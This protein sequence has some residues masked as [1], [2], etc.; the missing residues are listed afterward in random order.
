MFN[1][2][3][4]IKNLINGRSEDQIN[5]ELKEIIFNIKRKDYKLIINNYFFKYNS[6]KNKCIKI[7]FIKDSNIFYK[8]FIEKTALY[9]RLLFLDRFKELEHLKRVLLDI[10]KENNFYYLK[11]TFERMENLTMPRNFG[12]DNN[13]IYLNKIVDRFKYFNE[14]IKFILYYIHQ[15]IKGDDI[16]DY[17]DNEPI[18]KYY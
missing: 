5:E 6:I 17:Y 14:T 15:N 4:N 7:N 2:I 10:I 18:L 12:V 11:N 8:K 9:E 13:E 1:R 3:K 16:I